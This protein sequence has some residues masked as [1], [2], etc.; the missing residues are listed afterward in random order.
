VALVAIKASPLDATERLRSRHRLGSTHLLL[1]VWCNNCR[2][3]AD[4][5]PGEQ[6]ERHGV[7][8]DLFV[9]RSRL[10]CR[11]QGPA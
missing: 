11:R 10:R 2:R 5:N 7:D 3:I 4:L 1:R 6:A 9:W 8:L